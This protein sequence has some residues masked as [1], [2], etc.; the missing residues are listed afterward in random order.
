[1]TIARIAS[2]IAVFAS[3]AASSAAIASAQPVFDDSGSFDCTTMG[4][5]ICGPGNETGVVPGIY[6]PEG[7]LITAWED[8]APN[9]A[10]GSDIALGA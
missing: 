5:H 8:I 9:P 7:V 3:L 2:T 4:N 6:S 10:P 1:M